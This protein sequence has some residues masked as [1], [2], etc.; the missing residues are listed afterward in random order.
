[1]LKGYCLLRFKKKQSCANFVMQIS[2]NWLS[3]FLHVF[4]VDGHE[5]VLHRMNRVTQAASHLF[6]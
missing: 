4:G 2:L 5:A 6:S 3:S 1:M